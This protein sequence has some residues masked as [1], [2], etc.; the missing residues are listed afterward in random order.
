MVKIKDMEER[1]KAKAE[2][3]LRNNIKAFIVDVFDNYYFCEILFVDDDSIHVQHFT[4]KKQSEKERIF[5]PDIIRF[6]EY[7]NEG[8]EN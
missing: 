7:K 6:E 3:F 4:G 1:F 8:D 5:Y 2:I